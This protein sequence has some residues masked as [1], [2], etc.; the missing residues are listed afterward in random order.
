MS[1]RLF[2]YYC[3]VIGGLAAVAGWLLGRV[4]APSLPPD[5]TVGTYVLRASIQG[6]FLGAAVALGLGFVDA[7]WNL[8][9]RQSSAVMIR[10]LIVAGIGCLAG[11]I[12]GAVG[13]GLAQLIGLKI[14]QVAGWV[15]T[16]LLIGAAVAVYEAAQALTRGRNLDSSLAKMMKAGLGGA[17][18]GL[19]GGILWAVS[20]LIFAAISRAAAGYEGPDL[21]SPSLWGMAALGICLGLFIGGAQVVLRDA[22][23]KVESG[24]RAG[25]ELILTREETTVGRGESCDIGLF[26]DAAVEKVHCRILKQRD[27]FRVVDAGTPSGTFVNDQPVSKATVLKSGDRI[28]VGRSVLRFREREQRAG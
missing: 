5:A 2:L 14:L 15:L 16:G 25:R 9:S 27:H 11:I 7:L 22:W 17:V 6:L 28:R 10:G 19:L 4:L 20:H 18:G 21:Y 26:G 23:I 8:S 1:F 24:F 3:A 12:G 13:E